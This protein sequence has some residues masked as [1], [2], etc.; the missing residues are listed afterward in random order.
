MRKLTKVLPLIA[1]LVLTFGLFGCDTEVAEFESVKD[2][3]D[4]AQEEAK[5]V[6]KE[7]PKEKTAG[8]RQKNPDT[9]T[10][11]NNEELNRLLSNSLPD[12]EYIKFFE[13]NEYNI[14]EFDGAIDL[15][16]LIPN[17]KTRYS[18]V[19]RS[20]D[21]DA[22]SVVGP[23]FRVKDVGAAESSVKDLFLSG[24]GEVGKNVRIKAKIYG[25][26]EKSG[27]VELKLISM[28]LR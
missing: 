7:E 11:E 3:V 13:A 18:M 8:E 9:L 22:N 10:I 17:K 26:D 19:L 23:A 5:E 27:A 21:Y 20:G 4:T 6:E 25:Y 12:E 14:V 1:S 15:I 2:A 24:N 28:S 16:E